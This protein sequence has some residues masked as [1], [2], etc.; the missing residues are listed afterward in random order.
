MYINHSCTKTARLEHICTM[1]MAYT[2]TPKEA[3]LV[4]ALN[5]AVPIVRHSPQQPCRAYDHER[6]QHWPQQMGPQRQTWRNQR[7]PCTNCDLRNH[8][9]SECRLPL[10]HH[11]GQTKDYNRDKSANSRWT[12]GN[13][14]NRQ[15]TSYT[16]PASN[17][18]DYV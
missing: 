2:S 9:T 8:S 18:R 16:G 15:F 1:P 5:N 12:T 14:R 11:S 7:Q 10:R 17:Y 4:R 6:P 13:H 3:L